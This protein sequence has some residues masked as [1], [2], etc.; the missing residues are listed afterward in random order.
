MRTCSIADCTRKVHGHG[1]CGT[2]WARWKN[3]GSPYT[4]TR[5]R[6]GQGYTRPDGYRCLYGELEHRRVWIQ[7][8]GSIPKHLV[9]HHIN[10]IKTDNRLDNLELMPSGHHTTL[11]RRGKPGHR[12]TPETR[13]RLSEIAR[14]RYGKRRTICSISACP[15]WVRGHGFC[16]KHYQ[17][18][19]KHGDPAIVLAQGRDPRLGRLLSANAQ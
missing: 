1:W 7:A 18:W 13:A 12:H 8:Y 15:M 11:H 17:R 10:G 5:N 6:P 16:D 4:V 9:V 19:R 14:Q 3:H 2:H